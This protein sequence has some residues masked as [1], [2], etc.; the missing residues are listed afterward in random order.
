MVYVTHDQAEA[1]ALA[2]RVAVMRDGALRQTGAPMEIYRHPANRFVA[3]F[4][5][6]PP[7]NFF[8]G[9]LARDNGALVFRAGKERALAVPL[10]GGLAQ[11]LLA[12]AGQPVTLGLRPEHIGEGGGGPAPAAVERVEPA[13]A[14]NLVYC[15][16]DG[17]P[18]VM[19][20]PPSSA[21]KGGDGLMLRFDMGQA[22][23]FDPVT[24]QAL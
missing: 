15:S 22:H 14:E 4:I 7:M 10:E 21:V 20:A 1:M 16:I 9:T 18:L 5:G 13:G 8:E 24:G 17:L 3:G 19:R 11:T 2:D 12:R 23:F 6:S